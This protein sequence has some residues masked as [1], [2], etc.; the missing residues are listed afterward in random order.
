[1]DAQQRQR[2]RLAPGVVR[3]GGQTEQVSRDDKSRLLRDSPAC[4]LSR[5]N[6]T[7][8]EERCVCRMVQ[9]CQELI[10]K[11]RW[12]RLAGWCRRMRR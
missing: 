11:R 2:D 12:F 7:G 1:M 5:D 9:E 6:V 4:F 3:H 10:E 8:R